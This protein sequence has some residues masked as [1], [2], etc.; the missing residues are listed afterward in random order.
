MATL[1][2]TPLELWRASTLPNDTAKATEAYEAALRDGDA[3]AIAALRESV[4]ERIDAL[5]AFYIVNMDDNRAK[6]FKKQRL[7]LRKLLHKTPASVARP[8]ATEARGQNTEARLTL[9]EVLVW[10]LDT[11]SKQLPWLTEDAVQTIFKRHASEAKDGRM[12]LSDL[13][14]AI[15]DMAPRQAAPPRQAPGRGAGAPAGAGGGAGTSAGSPRMRSLG[16]ADDAGSVSS[17]GSPHSVSTTTTAARRRRKAKAIYAWEKASDDE[18]DGDEDGD[19]DAMVELKGGIAEFQI[20]MT[21]AEYAAYACKRRARAAE[22]KHMAR[23]S[24]PKTPQQ[25]RPL[26]RTLGQSGP[27]VEP[28]TLASIFYRNS[29]REKWITHDG[30]Q[31][32]PAPTKGVKPTVAT[33]IRA[34]Y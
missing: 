34:P 26:E 14:A 30:F 3:G 29:R 22:K 2:W 31:R 24:R 4:E 23:A 27:Y 12:S 21:A 7:K 13:H 33:V 32:S 11:G 9:A 17:L 20:R 28:S 19:M 6:L 15:A 25:D 16:G 1:S 10:Y 8:A 18:S 5:D